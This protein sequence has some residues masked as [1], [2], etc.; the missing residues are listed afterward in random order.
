[1][2][3]EQCVNEIETVVNKDEQNRC[4]FID[5][6]WG[7]GKTYGVKE[8][9]KEAIYISLFGI[10]SKDTLNNSFENELLNISL[11]N[12]DDGK[13]ILGTTSDI[14]SSI[15]NEKLDNKD[16]KNKNSVLKVISTLKVL[17]KFLDLVSLI[18]KIY[19]SMKDIS[20]KVIIID[21]LERTK[22]DLVVVEGFIDYL[23]KNRKANVILI[24]N[25]KQYEIEKNKDKEIA[26][27]KDKITDICYCI[28]EI[29]NETICKILDIKPDTDK[30]ILKFIASNT[31]K[32]LRVLRKTNKAY[33]HI[34]DMGISKDEEFDVDNLLKLVLLDIYNNDIIDSLLVKDDKK[35]QNIGDNKN[36]SNIIESLVENQIKSFVN[37]LDFKYYTPENLILSFRDTLKKKLIDGE[38]ITI[39]D[40]NYQLKFIIEEY[41]DKPFK[42]MTNDEIK[43]FINDDK[44]DYF[45]DNISEFGNYLRRVDRIIEYNNNVGSFQEN[46]KLM[47]KYEER[48]SN[49]SKEL[50]EYVL[51]NKKV[52]RHMLI[53]MF[54]MLNNKE[55]LK[56]SFKKI[57]TQEITN[58]VEENI[59][60]INNNIDNKQLFKIINKLKS[61][62]YCFDDISFKDKIANIKFEIRDIVYDKVSEDNLINIFNFLAESNF[63]YLTKVM[64]QFKNKNFKNIS[65]KIVCKELYNRF[66][67]LEKEVG[68]DTS[69]KV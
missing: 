68:R 6:D 10:D 23:I 25:L 39:D 58:D 47:Q 36:S 46:E 2:N 51:Y 33:C 45:I 41:K 16:V 14:I 18:R 53:G 54:E 15:N 59:C 50:I 65:A 63:E 31:I 61:I 60:L 67:T 48:I 5:G 3:I 32:N 40:V 57:I 42:H 1:M 21:D 62:I 8:K 7:I 52:F 24:G 49:R 20:N 22:L 34:K 9:F 38:N 66:E 13:N 55:M 44:N 29:S 26:K 17:S 37:Y 43:D 4:F 27:L 56:D 69:T 30:N 64:H 35:L 12:N 11:I 19:V 28:N